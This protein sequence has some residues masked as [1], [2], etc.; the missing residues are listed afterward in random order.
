MAPVPGSFGSWLK[1]ILAPLNG[2][3]IFAISLLTPPSLTSC[4]GRPSSDAPPSHPTHGVTVTFK[5]KTRPKQNP[6][7][8]RSAGGCCSFQKLLGHQNND[9]NANELRECLS[10]MR[11]LHINRGVLE[12][13]LRQAH[14]GG[15]RSLGK[16]HLRGLHKTI[17]F[18][19]PSWG[20]HGV[21][22]VI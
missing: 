3:G 14:N 8:R 12:P 13:P 1:G 17:S 20:G 18:L 11:L 4:W 9:N 15:P 16:S 2:G 10:S 22:G 19:E 7:G 21:G 5:V 6:E